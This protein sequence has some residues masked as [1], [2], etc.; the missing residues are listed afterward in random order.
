MFSLGQ[1]LR[2]AAGSQRNRVRFKRA[3]DR[4]CDYSMIP[5]RNFV[6]TLEIAQRVAHLEGCV[7]ECG[8]W[9]GGMA[10]A[11]AS[12]LGNRRPY[13]LL[14]SF[15]GMPPATAIDGDRAIAWEQNVT[16]PNYFDNCAAPSSH[17]IEIMTRAQVSDVRL[18]EGWFCETVPS[19]KPA[20][21][22]VVLHLDADWY[23]SIRVCLDHL[24]DF[25]T[26]GGLVIIDDYYVWDG[27][28]RALH[29]FLSSRS[30]TER[31]RTLGSICYLKKGSRFA[32]G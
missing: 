1:K 18:V 3:F 13:Y 31:V 9:R 21:P 12:V 19:F 10:A 15:Q 32:H 2:I 17:A 4:Y 29:D 30:A 7:V 16:G 20:E 11:L 24:F 23:D 6:H 26:P 25:V 22:I 14:D 27:C 28:S 8:V 5:K